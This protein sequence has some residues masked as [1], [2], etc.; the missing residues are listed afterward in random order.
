MWNTEGKIYTVL[1]FQ[2]SGII[3]EEGAGRVKEPKG[4]DN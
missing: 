1:F 2:V 3:V 4:I